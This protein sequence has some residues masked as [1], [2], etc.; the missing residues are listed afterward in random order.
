MQCIF[1]TNN[2]DANFTR[3]LNS[4]IEPFCLKSQEYRIANA[5]YFLPKKSKSKN[6]NSARCAASDFPRIL[7]PRI[8]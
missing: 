4:A 8:K 1:S 6:S 7:I 3:V 5:D 2:V